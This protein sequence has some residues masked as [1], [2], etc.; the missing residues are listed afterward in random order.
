MGHDGAKCGLGTWGGASSRW[1]WMRSI[2]TAPTAGRHRD[3][4]A[5]IWYTH[6]HSRCQRGSTSHGAMEAYNKDCTWS[7]PDGSWWCQ[8]WPGNKIPPRA[9]MFWGSSSSLMK[10]SGEVLCAT[11]VVLFQRERMASARLGPDNDHTTSWCEL[12]NAKKHAKPDGKSEHTICAASENR[13]FAQTLRQ[14]HELQE[15]LWHGWA[16]DIGTAPNDSKFTY[17]DTNGRHVASMHNTICVI[18]LRGTLATRMTRWFARF[19]TTWFE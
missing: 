13:A 5:P 6:V 16:T 2:S 8:L 11:S 15:F 18:P 12:K 17:A 7:H 9:A 10:P 4:R 19:R 14:Y 3:S 1:T